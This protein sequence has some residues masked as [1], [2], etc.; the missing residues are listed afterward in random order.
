VDTALLRRCKLTLF[1]WI[2]SLAPA[3]LPQAPSKPVV[4]Y[5]QGSTLTLA[6]ASGRTT[7][8]VRLAQPVFDFAISPDLQRMV[9]V[10][11]TTTYGGPL[12]LIQLDSGHRSRIVTGPVY[13]KRL[14]KGE[15]EVYADPRFSQDGKHV[16]FAVHVNSPGDSNDAVDA[17]GPVAVV[18]TSI[19][20]VRVIKSTMQIA[21][22]AEGPC[23]SNS[24]LWSHD[25]KRILFNCEDGAFI[26]DASGSAILDLRM[27]T[28]QKPW[29]SAIGWI[30]KSCVLYV[31]ATDGGSDETY[32]AELLNLH[33]SKSQ[34]ATAILPGLHNPVSGLMEASATVKVR[35]TPAGLQIETPTKTLT[36]PKGSTAH[37]LGGWKTPGIPHDCE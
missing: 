37:V 26:T 3:A 10:A 18:D 23:F 24:P 31:Q 8:T 16:A 29:T 36:L 13:F 35:R 11:P 9:T 22:E 17:A 19:G 32:E 25:G 21:G 33:T 7:K 12:D 4:A 27:G 6:D 1:L 5:V 34:D 2:A 30:G 20:Q 28:D 15:K 14:P